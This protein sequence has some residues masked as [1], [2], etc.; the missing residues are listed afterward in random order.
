MDNSGCTV[1]DVGWVTCWRTMTK[2]SSVDR[3]TIADF[4]VFLEY[5]C[6]WALVLTLQ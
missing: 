3:S 5:V 2:D 1:A 6:D 4:L